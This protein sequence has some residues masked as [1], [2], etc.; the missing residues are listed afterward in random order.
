MSFGTG[1]ATFADSS[2]GD[3]V[4]IYSGVQLTVPNGYISDSPLS[5][6]ATWDFATFSSLGVTPGTYEWAWGTG[7]NQN[8]VL[9]IV[10]VPEPCSIVPVA[11]ILLGW[12][13]SRIA[14]R[15]I[16]RA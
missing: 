14:R 4:A 13:G 6:S 5:D 1:V 8:F 2:I 11:V 16:A 10:S 3:T 9:D 15:A 7:A 12:L